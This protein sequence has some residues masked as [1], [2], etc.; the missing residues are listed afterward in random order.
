MRKRTSPHRRSRATTSGVPR[1]L[2]R[3]VAFASSARLWTITPIV[4]AVEDV[5]L[6]RLRADVMLTCL[7]SRSARQWVNEAVWRLGVPWV[8]AGVEPSGLLARISVFAPGA[9]SPCLECG[10]SEADFAA[11]EQSYPC[12]GDAAAA[13]TDAPS[14]L[15]ALAASLQAIEL[16]KILAGDTARVAVGREVVIDASWHRHYLTKLT[17]NPRCRFDHGVWHIEPTDPGGV[18]GII[19]A[20]ARRSTGTRQTLR[21]HGRL[22]A[23]RL[24]C[25]DCGAVKETMRLVGRDGQMRQPCR[26]CGGLLAVSGAD[27]IEEVDLTRLTGG[28]RRRSLRRVGLRAGDVISLTG[29]N[30]ERHLELTQPS[31]RGVE[32]RAGRVKHS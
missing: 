5:P 9:D 10:W 32:V 17:R 26:R 3:R 19:P 12:G 18:S 7:D 30:G 6:G 1:R 24:C 16:R 31:P 20:P 22:F 25:R 23:T 14:S 29:S 2:S 8:D 21:V 27:L 28:A 11:L 13:P 15:G 4:A